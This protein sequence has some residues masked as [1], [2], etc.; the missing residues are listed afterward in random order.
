MLGS[1]VV[2]FRE[3]L[4]AALIIAI[5][6]GASRG[7][8]ARVQWVFGGVALGLLGA[9]VV[10]LFAGF[11]ADAMQGRGQ[12]LFNAAVLLVAVA[13]LAWHNIWMSGHAR[14]HAA[15]MQA[16]GHDVRA[17]LRPLS[18]MLLV[19]ALA[20]LR[21]GAE[22][23]LFLYGLFASGGERV[24]L[25]AG[26][27]VGLGGGAI[28]GC[29]L[30]F[31]LVR[32]PLRQF[33]RVTGLIV[34]LLAAGLAAGAAGYL[35]QADLLPV[36]SEQ[37]WDTSGTLS[38]ESLPGRILHVLIGYVDRPTGIELVFY[39]ATLA[40]IGGMMKFVAARTTKQAG[41]PSLL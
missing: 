21:E 13:M 38:V 9:V 39:V 20:V 31:G 6:L 41:A 37:V 33:F 22:T 18:A 16:L 35:A 27:L 32:I 15:E 11:I 26:A 29:L 5:V 28:V 12:E 23:V 1:A 2:V 14:K 30:Y 17:G 40:I 19:T 4:E 3:T 34:L 8:A 10:A 25:A 7:M 24:E 36:L